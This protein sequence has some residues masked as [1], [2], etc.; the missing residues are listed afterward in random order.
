M[1]EQRS[2][3]TA[4]K[5]DAQGNEEGRKKTPPMTRTAESAQ[6]CHKLR[7]CACWYPFSRLATLAAHRHIFWLTMEHKTFESSAEGLQTLL[8]FLC[9]CVPRGLVFQQD[10]TQ[11]VQRRR[12]APFNTTSALCG[13]QKHPNEAIYRIPKQP[14]AV[15]FVAISF[16]AVALNGLC[17]RLRC[18]MCLFLIIHKNRH[19]PHVSGRALI[20]AHPS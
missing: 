4:A 14:S 15:G 10:A 18:E 17:E 2:P 1:T 8:Q 20:D 9:P 11:Q 6:R 3:A 19:A 16:F 12:Y 7:H 5:Q 13:L